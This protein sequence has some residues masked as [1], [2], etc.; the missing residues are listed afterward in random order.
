[1]EQQMS[2]AKQ[3]SGWYDVIAC[4]SG[5]RGSVGERVNNHLEA[6]IRI[7]GN[8]YPIS[9]PSDSGRINLPQYERTAGEALFR[10]C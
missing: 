4:T 8:L 3:S 6:E 7:K 10:G 2:R 9:T 1:M 5:G